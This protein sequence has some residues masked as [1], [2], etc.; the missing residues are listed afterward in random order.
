[1]AS[2][3]TT[4]TA[5]RVDTPA[6]T[7]PDT[8]SHLAA[9]DA[10]SPGDPASPPDPLQPDTDVEVDAAGDDTRSLL[11]LAGSVIAPTTF[12]TALLFYFGWSHA[13]WFFHYF[14]INATVLDLTTR[15]FVMRSVDGLFM[16]V[17]Y[18]AFVGVVAVWL[19]RLAQRWVPD[20]LWAA[21]R[22]VMATVQTPIGVA[23]TAVGMWGA[24]AQTPLEVNVAVSPACLG[25][26]AILLT[27]GSRRRSLRAASAAPRWVTLWA[28]AGMLV[29]AGLSLFWVAHDYSADV[30]A[31]RARQLEL[32]LVDEPSVTLYSAKRLNL[33]ARGIREAVCEGSNTAYRFRYDGLR[34]VQQ[35]GDQYVLLPAAWSRRDG[36]AILLPRDPDTRLEFAPPNTSTQRPAT[37]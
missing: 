15:D 9:P 28:W 37:C 3:R 7:V 31:S 36:V 8:S 5:D 1:M 29:L 6:V 18:L 33:D 2:S 17:V 32:E 19:Y 11:K 20:H 14:G 21:A 26:G 23:L 13:Y 35:A 27:H 22:R 25:V 30:G 16:P 12:V 34:L 4:P 10:A 24:V